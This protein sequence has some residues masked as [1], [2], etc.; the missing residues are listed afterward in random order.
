VYQDYGFS[1][2]TRS[3]EVHNNFALPGWCI[4]RSAI[5]QAEIREVLVDAIV[6]GK[7][8]VY[9]RALSAKDFR[10]CLSP[11]VL[12]QLSDSHPG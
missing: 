5:I 2:W 9:V 4:K 11:V 12:D 6:T 10:V 1:V 7:N 3:H 8:G